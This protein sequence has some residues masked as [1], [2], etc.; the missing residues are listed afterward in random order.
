MYL[1]AAAPLLIPGSFGFLAVSVD[2]HPL[3]ETPTEPEDHHGGD[4]SSEIS[5]QTADAAPA[6]D[7]VANVP[8]AGGRA[9]QESSSAPVGLTSSSL[10]ATTSEL[11]TV[12]KLSPKVKRSLAI[13]AECVSNLSDDDGPATEDD[14]E[15][16]TSGE[17]VP[18]CGFD[19]LLTYDEWSLR[20]HSGGS[21]S[22]RPRRRFL[23]TARHDDLIRPA[24][25]PIWSSAQSCPQLVR[26][27]AFLAIVV[28]LLCG[29]DGAARF[30]LE[31]VRQ[32][33][34][35]AQH[36]DTDNR[37]NVLALHGPYRQPV[38]FQTWCAD[39]KS[40]LPS[41][42]PLSQKLCGVGEEEGEDGRDEW[43]PSLAELERLARD[44]HFA[45]S[46]DEVLRCAEDV[47]MPRVPYGMEQGWQPQA[48]GFGRGRR[49]RWVRKG[50]E[51]GGEVGWVGCWL[52]ADFL[53]FE[54]N[55]KSRVV[56][57][58]GGCALLS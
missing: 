42:T 32:I 36:T 25:R 39:T 45:G 24:A 30:V 1:L 18:V 3:N 2:Q 10:P 13:L 48:V 50:R 12:P 9:A 23:K 22:A 5:W 47:V 55:V 53:V 11:E 40:R 6:Q 15:T 46:F 26:A 20:Q 21:R 51:Q 57:C 19:P 35:L 38:Q 58:F 4:A 33:I 8:P 56:K 49:V 27:A 31:P 44:M 28:L 41:C 34:G 16:E 17:E 43:Q 52:G 14:P 37:P 7:D 29:G 54:F